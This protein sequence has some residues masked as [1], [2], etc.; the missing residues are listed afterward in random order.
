[1][2][3]GVLSKYKKEDEKL[4]LSKIMDKINFCETRNK[5]QVTDFFDLGQKQL[6]KNLKI[7]CFMVDL[8]RQKEL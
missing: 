4:V 6:V 7:I 5:I 3:R 2:D 8:K 1:M